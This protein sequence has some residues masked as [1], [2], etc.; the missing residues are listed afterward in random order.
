MRN[1]RASGSVA[2][3]LTDDEYRYLIEEAIVVGRCLISGCRHLPV[4]HSDDASGWP[5]QITGCPCKN[6]VVGYGK[7]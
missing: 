3:V 5:C 1:S 6:M 7:G 2:V 4:F